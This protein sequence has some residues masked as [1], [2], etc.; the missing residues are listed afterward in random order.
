[1]IICLTTA[2]TLSACGD[3]S[4]EGQDSVAEPKTWKEDA[5]TNDMKSY[6]RFFRTTCMYN[7][8]LAYLY[9]NPGVEYDSEECE[10]WED[11]TNYEYL[12]CSMETLIEKFQQES[13]SHLFA[14]KYLEELDKTNYYELDETEKMLFELYV[15]FLFLNESSYGLALSDTAQKKDIRALY[16]FEADKINSV[17]GAYMN[18]SG[19]V[20]SLC[21]SNLKEKNGIAFNFNFDNEYYI[22]TYVND[23]FTFYNTRESEIFNTNEQEVDIKE[24]LQ[25]IVNDNIEFFEFLI[26]YRDC[27]YK[28]IRAE[29]SDIVLSINPNAFVVRALE[30]EDKGEGEPEIGMTA[31]EVTNS[32]WGNPDRKNIDEY[33]FGIHQQWVYE[34]RGYI[35]F[36]D[37]KVTSISYRY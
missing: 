29:E 15:K 5:M 13:D 33:E 4:S 2:F 9:A 10:A 25:K 1:M 16:N 37:G 19:N 17:E 12:D 34:N 26:E 28:D 18:T 6:S 14:A 8:M 22:F 21:W 32:T 35:Y 11:R 24:T 20:T 36:E 23:R 7:C 30:P 3:K 31:E 27:V